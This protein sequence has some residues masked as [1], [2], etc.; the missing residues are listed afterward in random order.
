MGGPEQ[1]DLIEYPAG[2]AGPAEL[3][4]SMFSGSAAAAMACVQHEPPCL[5]GAEHSVECVQNGHIGSA[6]RNES[7][8]SDAEPNAAAAPMS[9]RRLLVCLFV[10]GWSGHELPRQTGRP[11]TMVRRWTGG[12]SPVPADVAAWIEMLAASHQAH[13]AP[14]AGGAL[15]TSTR[16]MGRLIAGWQSG[17]SG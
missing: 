5:R 4:P 9:P 6:P 10:I 1:T 2:E 15:D 7:G 12:R 8:K 3:Q 14:R 13:P 16:K 17:N 11:Q